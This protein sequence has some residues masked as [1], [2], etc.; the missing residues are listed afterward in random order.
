MALPK[1]VGMVQHVWIYG[2]GRFLLLAN[3][4]F[5]DLTELGL[6]CEFRPR[7]DGKFQLV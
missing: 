6:A 2:K 3:F 7:K 1:T 5:A 4:M